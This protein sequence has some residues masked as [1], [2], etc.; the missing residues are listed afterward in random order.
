MLLFQAIL[1][2]ACIFTESRIA[3]IGKKT[4]LP[5]TWVVFQGDR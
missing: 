1:N 3:E 5:M 2:T 4:F